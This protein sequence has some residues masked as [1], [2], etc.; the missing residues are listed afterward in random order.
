[1]LRKMVNKK[2]ILGSLGSTLAIYLAYEYNPF[3][4]KVMLSYDNNEFNSQVL[5]GLTQLTQGHF[6]PSPVCTTALQQSIMNNQVHEATV[7]FNREPLVLPDGGQVTLDWALPTKRIEFIGTP[8]FGKYYPYEP[9]KDSKIMF[10]IHGL[11]GGSETQYIQTLVQAACQKGYRVVVMNQRGINQPLTTPMPFHGGHH[12][13]LEFAISHVKRK[14]PN[15]PLLAVGTSFGG[16]QLLRYLGDNPNKKDFDAGVLLSAPFDLED[17]LK[18]VENSVYEEFFIK[19]YFEKTFLPHIDTYQALAES[20][21]ILVEDILKVKSLRDYHSLFTVKLYEHKDIQDY[22][23]LSKVFDSHINNVKIPLLVLHSKDDPIAVSK[24]IPVETL[25]KNPNIIYAETKR[26][27]HLCWFTGFKP[28]RWYC[29]PTIEFLDKVLEL[30][31]KEKK[32]TVP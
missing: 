18:G 32:E 30:Q 3:V 1:M 22:F 28:R 15:A 2:T 23:I 27:G 10:I 24:S 9:S 12:K 11:T 21:G 29:N 19:S 26:G 6:Y 4:T 8:V 20:H 25:A 7:R 31:K 17:C 5:S 13:D 16:N 14:Y